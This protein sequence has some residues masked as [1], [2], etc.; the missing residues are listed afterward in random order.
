MERS[1]IARR[2]LTLKSWRVLCLT[3]IS[4]QQD[5]RRLARRVERVSVSSV[6]SLNAARPSLHRKALGRGHY[7]DAICEPAV[8]GCRYESPL[9]FLRLHEKSTV[10]IDNGT[11][12][13]NAL[14]GAHPG[15]CRS[16]R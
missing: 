7:Q 16:Y 10:A 2:G 11:G 15:D 13:Q 6:R 5:P 4:G 8:R 14:P 9:N 1:T 12:Q 3:R